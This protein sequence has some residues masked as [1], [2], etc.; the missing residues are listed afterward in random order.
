MRRQCFMGEKFLPQLNRS[1]PQYQVATWNEQLKSFCLTSR[2]SLVVLWEFHV[3]L[4]TLPSISREPSSCWCTTCT[5]HDEWGSGSFIPFS[6]MTDLSQAHAK[7]GHMICEHFPQP[8][9]S[10]CVLDA[11]ITTCAH[12]KSWVKTNQNLSTVFSCDCD[13]TG[14]LSLD[15]LLLYHGSE[16]LAF[17]NPSQSMLLIPRLVQFWLLHSWKFSCNN[18]KS[19]LL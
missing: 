19:F 13:C 8:G 10:G 6:L 1:R 4:E 3:I 5:S 2:V 18:I 17:H 16:P 14:P 9:P 15:L 7:I 12:P 11:D